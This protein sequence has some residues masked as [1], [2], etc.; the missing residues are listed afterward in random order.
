MGRFSLS[1]PGNNA[2][3]LRR[4]LQNLQPPVALGRRGQS[5]KSVFSIIPRFIDHYLYGY[6]KDEKATKGWILSK[7]LGLNSTRLLPAGDRLG[8]DEPQ[9]LVQVD[10]IV[11]GERLEVVL[12]VGLVDDVLVDGVRGLA[13]A[14][15]DSPRSVV[16]RRGTRRRHSTQTTQNAFVK[17]TNRKI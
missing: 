14:P 16:P 3:M 9:E 4:V 5:Q 13:G 8:V 12:V 10:P 17:S 11:F 2:V 15:R 6:N 1:N 7:T